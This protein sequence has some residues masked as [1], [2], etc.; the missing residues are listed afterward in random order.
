M[1]INIG[2]EPQKHGVF[3]EALEPLLSV[4]EAQPELQLSGLMTIPPHTEDP[5]RAL[6]YFTE[7]RNL[8]DA[9]GGARRLPNLSMGM[10]DDFSFAIEAGATLVRVGTAIFG[11]RGK[12]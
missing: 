6:S 3:A 10:S 9:H 1:E 5:A 8:R 4:I 12:D 11:E 2:R 7:M